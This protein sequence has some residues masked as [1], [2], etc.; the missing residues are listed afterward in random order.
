M[1]D[2][3][4]N[5]EPEAPPLSSPEAAFREGKLAAAAGCPRCLNPYDR[6]DYRQ[7]RAADWFAG[8]DALQS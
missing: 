2:W 5:K 4:V 3:I 8:F 1:T 6:K 7:E